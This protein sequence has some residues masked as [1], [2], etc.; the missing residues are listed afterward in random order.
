LGGLRHA[1][2]DSK[3][4]GW[5]NPSF[6]GFADYMQTQAF[7]EALETLI[8]LGSERPTVIMCAEAVPWRCHRSLIADALVVHGFA[9]EHIM[10]PGVS[11]IHSLHPLAVVDQKS[12]TYPSPPP[13]PRR[14]VEPSPTRTAKN[15]A[16]ETAGG[17]AL[18]SFALV[19]WQVAVDDI[20]NGVTR[21]L[22]LSTVAGMLAILIYLCFALVSYAYYPAAF[23]PQD[24]WLSDLGNAD[25]N[26]TGALFYRLGS[27]LTGVV[28][29]LFFIGLCVIARGHSTRV[30]V[31]VVLSQ[32]F[33]VIGAFALLMSGIFS[34]GAH[35]SHALWSIML[36][37]ALG[38]AMFFCGW[39]FLYFPRLSRHLSYFAFAVTVLNWVM[40]AFNK[41]HLIEWIVVALMLVF[42]GMVSCRMSRVDSW[43]RIERPGMETQLR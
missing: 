39:A 42:F 24:N 12:V 8:A 3:N 13:A 21:R 19:R 5:Q 33:G 35:A 10:R 41:T 11:R 17:R 34:L 6:R 30:K 27:G 1:R 15:S 37:I 38:T 25:L 36:Y 16:S 32:V 22:T 2:A 29:A 9:V 23:N 14:L 20:V 4:L 31:F 7:A 40:A 26:P 28:V 18:A 43:R